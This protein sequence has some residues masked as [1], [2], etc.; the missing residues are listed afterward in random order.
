MVIIMKTK[1]LRIICTLLMLTLAASMIFIVPAAAAFNPSDDDYTVDFSGARTLTGIAI[2]TTIGE[3]KAAC[4]GG[5]VTAA[6]IGGETAA[7]SELVGTGCTFTVSDG[8]T[9]TDT[10]KTVVFGDIT[11]DG[12][13]SSSDVLGMQMNL[14]GISAASGSPLL[15]C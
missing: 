7:D 9:S 12:I 15:A 10:F 6:R 4:S 13:I 11:G 3:V 5:A 2:G 8:G 14:L 1:A